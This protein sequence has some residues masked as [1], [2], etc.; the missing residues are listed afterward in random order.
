MAVVS[1]DGSWLQ[2]NESLCKL[3][4]YSEQ[5]LRAT[6]FQRLTHAEDLRHVQSYIQRVLE[7]YIQ[8]HEQE[9]RYIHEQGHP[10]WVQW[11]VSLLKDSETG[12]KRLFFQVQDISDR[13]KAEEKL[14]QDTLTGLPN[15]AR[16]YDLLKLRVSR[17]DQQCAVLLLDVDRFKLVND[18][19]GNASADQLLIQIAQRVKTCMRQGDVLARVGGDEFAVLLDDVSGEDEASSVAVRI[20]QALAISFNLLGQ[21]VYTT[22]SIGIALASDN[23]EQASDILR[24]A[25]TAMH[26]AKARGKARYEIF[27]HDMH[28]ELMSQLKMET[29][30]RRACER[31]E[32]FVDYQPIVSLGDRT[33]IGFEALVRWRHPEFGLVPP[34]DFIPVAEETGQI[35]T[36]GQT[37]LESACRQAHE[38]L[39]TYPATPPLFVSV[40]LSVKQFNQPGLV[41]NIANL[42]NEFKLPPRCLKLEITESVF[43]DNIEAAVGLLTQLRELG[44][45][46]SI[47]DFG[48]GYSS[49]SYLQRFPIDT[50]KIDRSFV[51]QMME[52]E[53]NLAIIR[54]IVALAQTLGMDV[55]AE[56]VETE[57]QLKLLRK[58]E[59]EN[60]QGYLFSTPLGDEQIE[61]FIADYVDAPT[62]LV[63]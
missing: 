8:S 50:L 1:V 58:L 4:G 15:R 2:V 21:E 62:A 49:L 45:Q 34:K 55:V 51:M 38:W 13:K 59:C 39:T 23:S 24:D 46:L 47:D 29:D 27:G 41:E 9:K 37:V 56:G 14:T 60:G 18:S 17:R 10:V 30:L 3:L 25:E 5:E 36:I 7:G 32:L 53:E 35:L 31:G 61:Q 57:D 43:S 33:L 48:T 40:N 54:T 12:T 11:H 6:S 63:A 26:T 19:L 52:N 16:F 20:Q 28:G 42:L 22:L 44:V